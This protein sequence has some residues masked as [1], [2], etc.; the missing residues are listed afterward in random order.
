MY[1][2]KARVVYWKIYAAIYPPEHMLN[3]RQ[4]DKYFRPNEMKK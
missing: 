4:Y 2:I 1:E 3:N